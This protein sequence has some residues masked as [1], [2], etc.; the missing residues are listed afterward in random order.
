[1]SVTWKQAD[2]IEGQNVRE[3]TIIKGQE[4]ELHVS[5]DI[6]APGNLMYTACRQAVDALAEIVKH[7]KDFEANTKDENNEMFENALFQYSG[8]II[9]FVGQRGAGKTQTMLSFSHGMA[10]GNAIFQDKTEL[11]NC[12]F[13]VMPPISPSVLTEAKNFLYVVLSRIYRYINRAL[14]NMPHRGSHM[15]EDDSLQAKLWETFNRCVSGINGISAGQKEITNTMELQDTMDGLSLQENFY[16]L[17]SQAVNKI[18]PKKWEEEIFIVLQLDDADSQIENGYAVLEDVRRYL[19]IPNLVILMS[20][21]MEILRSVVLQNHMK[22]FPDLVKEGGF[23]QNELPRICRKYID[24]LIPPSQLIHL[25]RLEQYAD[26]GRADIRLNYIDAYEK[27]V[28]SWAADMPELKLQDL[29]LTMIF[30][31]TGIIF[32]SQESQLN[33]IIPRSLRGLNQLIYFL[34]EMEDIPGIDARDWKRPF[35][36]AVGVREQSRIALRNLERFSD[37]FFYDW[38]DVKVHDSS[39]REFLRTLVGTP[40]NNF[41]YEVQGYMK[42]KYKR[43]VWE[44]VWEGENWTLYDLDKAL[45]NLEHNS[46]GTKDRL[47]FFIIGTVRTLYGHMAAWQIKKQTA[48]RVL[49]SSSPRRDSII[50]RSEHLFVCDYDPPKWNITAA[51]PVYKNGSYPLLARTKQSHPLYLITTGKEAMQIREDWKKQ[52]TKRITSSSEPESEDALENIFKDVF[53]DP[54][55]ESINLLNFI[56]LF[57]RLDNK[58]FN[59]EDITFETDQ[60]YIYR[61]QEMALQI[62]LNWDVMTRVCN[63]LV[64][65]ISVMEKPQEP[66]LVSSLRITFQC[67]D[68]ILGNMNQGAVKYFWDGM[69]PETGYS[70]LDTIGMLF[71]AGRQSVENNQIRN[72]LHLGELTEYIQRG[73]SMFHPKSDNS[74]YPIKKA[75]MAESTDLMKTPP[76][77]S[78]VTYRQSWE[79]LIKALKANLPDSPEYKEKIQ[80]LTKLMSSQIKERNPQITDEH[81]KQMFR[82]MKTLSQQIQSTKAEN[83][84][85]LKPEEKP[86]PSE[87]EPSAD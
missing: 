58:A 60:A 59:Y 24:K 21:D 13:F 56:T 85:S 12:R 69:D 6:F 46:I 54:K 14:E 41:V 22:Q 38:I 64:E 35:Q 37:Y 77:K 15:Q 70:L 30:K 11:R 75:G 87:G 79:S 66:D 63:E 73:E 18:L 10:S 45:I 19:Q 7:T 80:E 5:D 47:L 44:E 16:T 28:M 81:N 83:S 72:N 25:P 17:I 53:I 50:L 67:V 71:R 78:D 40:R 20:T 31:K 36:L 27:P 4:L 26:M 82:L 43:T 33:H 76:N 29:L 2:E 62:A 51:Y 57:L 32:L 49:T 68:D 23:I 61:T 42:E 86:N 9:A 84:S 8:N 39:D 65:K 34:S 74:K 52:E 48:D 1:M 3:L 55:D